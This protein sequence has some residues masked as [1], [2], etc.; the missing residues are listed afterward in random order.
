MVFIYFAIIVVLFLIY[1]FKPKTFKEINSKTFKTIRK[2]GEKEEF[3]INF[4]IIG[5][6][7]IYNQTQTIL[8]Q[9]KFTPIHLRAALQ[10]LQEGQQVLQTGIHEN[11]GSYFFHLFINPSKLIRM[12]IIER[13]SDDQ[14]KSVHTFMCNNA[15]PCY[16]KN[17]DYL[18]WEIQFLYDKNGENHEVILSS[19]HGIIDGVSR[20][21]FAKQLIECLEVT[22]EN[23]KEIKKYKFPESQEKL[24]G[25]QWNL[26]KPYSSYF[27]SDFLRGILML[28]FE[29][30]KHEKLP[31]DQHSPPNER[32]DKFL[33]HTIPSREMDI[34]LKYCKINTITFHTFICSLVVKTSSEVWK[35]KDGYNLGVSM[36]IGLRQYLK[37]KIEPEQMGVMNSFIN[38]NC[39]IKTESFKDLTLRVHQLIKE[40]LVQKAGCNFFKFSSFTSLAKNLSKQMLSDR[41]SEGRSGQISV[42]NLG[43]FDNPKS[44]SFVLRGCF[45]QESQSAFGNN[46]SLYLVT[47]EN[48]CFITFGYTSPLLSDERAESFTKIFQQ[49][50]NEITQN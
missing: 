36:P 9:G 16:I 42:S 32:I 38:F 40:D 2:C 19:C 1:F 44:N 26:F 41:K 12:N 22:K 21:I 46:L 50:V 13:T 30:S 6:N 11:N 29:S 5:E 10:L 27:L 35:L 17:K 47:F 43:K 25:D 48:E 34:I 4:Q 37:N 7:K 31:I 33:C 49:K 8:I 39:P 23:G 14:W 18:L 20:S 3:N 28:L 45:A 15:P 24:L